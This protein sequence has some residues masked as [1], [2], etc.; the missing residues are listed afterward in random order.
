MSEEHPNHQ[1]TPAGI[2]RREVL[3][4][5]SA[6]A[7]GAALHLTTVQLAKAVSSSPSRPHLHWF[8]DSGTDHTL[9]ALQGHSMPGYADLVTNRWEMVAHRGIFPT[10]FRPERY[11]FQ[12]PII[13]VL[14]TIP[15]PAAIT[16][17]EREAFEKLV[18]MGKTLIL[19]G[20]EACYGG[21]SIPAKRIGW[22][23]EMAKRLR[24]PLLKLPGVPVPPH[25]LVGVLAHLEYLGFPRLDAHLRPLLYYSQTI[26]EAC[27]HRRSLEAGMFAR[28]F[29]DEGCLLE[30]GCK[31]QTTYNSCSTTGWNGGNSWCVG[32]G[33]PCVGCSE[34]WYPAHGGLGLYGRQSP[35]VSGVR[36]KIWQNVEGIGLGLLGISVAGTVLHLLRKAF[37][38]DSEE[39]EDS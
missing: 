6:S 38:P 25:H 12:S 31:G 26:C 9:L 11:T 24:T 19:V 23:K 37:A 29:G 2:T 32:A 15:D 17:G 3:R 30:L 33:G 10:G 13:L 5:L 28:D 16:P 4:L 22:L 7:A 35:G 18:S 20:T 14:E 21:I 39:L 27:E 1:S 34:P 36:G 8:N